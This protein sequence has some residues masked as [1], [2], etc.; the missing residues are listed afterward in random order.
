MAATYA[1]ARSYSDNATGSQT[2]MGSRWTSTGQTAYLA[3]DRFRL[4]FQNSDGSSHVVYWMRGNDVREWDATNGL[5]RLTDISEALARSTGASAWS[6]DIGHWIPSMLFDHPLKGNLLP[7]L[8]DPRLLSDDRVD[9]HPCFR[10]EGTLA[11]GPV[12]VWID[13]SS[14]LVRRVDSKSALGP[15]SAV[16]DPQV[17]GPVDPTAL[18]FNVADTR[19]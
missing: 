15:A 8:K 11:V 6:A 19:T 4:E 9:G 17:N 5:K 13:Q 1:N 18:E 7:R 12:T 3:P 14:Y 2:F 10:V 16:Y